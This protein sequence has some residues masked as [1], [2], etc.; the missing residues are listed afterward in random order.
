MEAME[1]PQDSGVHRWGEGG[2]A[3]LVQKRE[4][5]GGFNFVKK[6]LEG[7]LT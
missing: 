1:K 4:G 7:T 3:V 6:S 2:P 5:E